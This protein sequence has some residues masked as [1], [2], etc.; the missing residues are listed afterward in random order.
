[1]T[2]GIAAPKLDLDAKAKNKDDFEARF[3]RNF[4]RKM[5]ENY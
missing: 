2:I 5:K 3:N 1:M 4:R